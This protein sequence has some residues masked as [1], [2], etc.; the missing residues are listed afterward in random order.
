MK[1]QKQ[2]V[3]VLYNSSDLWES[4]SEYKVTKT[5]NYKSEMF[6]IFTNVKS[7]FKFQRISTDGLVFKLHYRETVSIL[8]IFCITLSTCQ[9][10]GEP[11]DCIHNKDL[12][13]NLIN[14]YCWIHSTFSM[15][16]AFHKIGSVDISHPGIEN[17]LGGQKPKKEHRYYQWVVLCLFLQV[18]SWFRC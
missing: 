14:A 5:E 2:R 4:N 12:P 13:N 16:S 17:S 7:L 8:V 18:S 15:R 1:K 11:I 10:V 3:R 9:F 6:N